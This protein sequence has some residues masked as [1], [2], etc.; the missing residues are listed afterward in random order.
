MCTRSSSTTRTNICDVTT[1]I[2]GATAIN[3]EMIPHSQRSVSSPSVMYKRVLR[4]A[5]SHL[6]ESE[7]RRIDANRDWLMTRLWAYLRNPTKLHGG[8][9][10][11]AIV[12]RFHFFNG[13]D[14]YCE[15]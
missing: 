11:V 9:S 5:R 6:V 3:G 13:T 15:P 1:G 2:L 4:K 12:C 10:Y 14:S 7:Q 8:L